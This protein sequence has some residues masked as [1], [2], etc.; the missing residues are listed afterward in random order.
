[1]PPS[2]PR[3]SRDELVAT[4]SDFYTFLTR[5]HIPASVVK[6]PPPE[7]WANITP[8][9][10]KRSG[11]SALVIDLIKHL[12]YI[13]EADAREEITNIHYKCDVVDYSSRTAEEFADIAGS[14]YSLVYWIERL[15]EK[16][17]KHSV[18]ENTNDATEDATQTSEDAD[19]AERSS[20]NNNTEEDCDSTKNEDLASCDSW[21]LSDDPVRSDLPNFI[22]IAEGYESGGRMIILDVLKG[23]IYEDIIRYTNLGAVDVV[24]FFRDL[25]GQFERLELVPIRGTMFEDEY[26]TDEEAQEYKDIYRQYGWPHESFRKEEALAAIEECRQRRL[27]EEEIK[28]QDRVL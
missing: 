25:K 28:Q 3:Y 12:P 24:D 7:G 21:G 22:T 27:R 26:D 15:E 23:V 11:K 17:S 19:T 18:E 6:Y 16:K 1:M 4:I 5:L 13:D 20:E 2:T 8:E 10:T 9:T 14:E